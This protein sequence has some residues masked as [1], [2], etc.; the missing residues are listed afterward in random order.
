VS[1]KLFQ[2]NF[3]V[4]GFFEKGIKPVLSDDLKGSLFI[5]KFFTRGFIGIGAGQFIF[6]RG[7]SLSGY[8]CG[9]G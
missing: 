7:L 2:L 9:C 6:C 3:T 5:S 1:G 4:S 8:V